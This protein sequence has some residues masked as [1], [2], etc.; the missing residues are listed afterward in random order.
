[1]EEDLIIEKIVLFNP[2]LP[3]IYGN[4]DFLALSFFYFTPVQIPRGCVSKPLPP[5]PPQVD[6]AGYIY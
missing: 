6:L 2:N 1:M 3:G 5:H 4:G